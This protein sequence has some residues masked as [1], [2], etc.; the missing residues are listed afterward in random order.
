MFRIGLLSP[1]PSDEI[2]LIV[3]IDNDSYGTIVQ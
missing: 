2:V 1:T 3:R